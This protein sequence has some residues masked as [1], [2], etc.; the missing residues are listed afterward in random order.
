M[1]DF[2][3]IAHS[4]EGIPRFD[5]STTLLFHDY[6]AF[7]ADPRWDRPSQFAAI[8]TD[9]EFQPIGKPMIWY[10]QPTPDYLPAPQACLITGITPQKAAREGLIEA[11]FIA[12]IDAVMREPETC[13]LGYNTV[14]YDDEMTR[15][16][17]YRNLRDPYAREWQNGNSRWD[18]IDV[19]RACYALRPQGM[20]WP[21]REDRSPSFKLEHLSQANGIEHGEAHDALADVR[22]TIGLAQKIKQAQPKLFDYLFKLRSKHALADLI[23]VQ[24]LQPLVHVSSRY[25]ASQGCCTWVVPVAWHPHNRN[26]V[27]AINLH[28]DISVLYDYSAEQLQ[29]WLYTRHDELA[30]RGLS[31]VPLKLIHLNK[32]PVLAPAKTLS[33]ERAAELG[34]DRD[35]CLNQLHQL[36]TQRQWQDKVVAVYQQSPDYAATD[37][38]GAL[39]EGFIDNADRQQAEALLQQPPAALAGVTAPF[40]DQRL[41]TLLFRYRARN[42]PTTLSEQELARWQNFCRERLMDDSADTPWRNIYQFTAEL[43]QAAQANEHNEQAIAILKALYQ[44]AES[45]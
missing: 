9:L 16:T 32:C 36:R 40:N 25:P 3:Q 19:A 6:E 5:L 31:P 20:T 39:Y 4:D 27:I 23:D 44:Y 30:A 1:L 24:Q 22:A 7:G 13:S 35:Y 28:Q 38:D 18:L 21:L 8:R 15:F 12:K 43:E 17:L 33:A 26:A 2:C 34:I 37:A 45:L 10:C 14:R 42:Y 11:E 41:N 29:E